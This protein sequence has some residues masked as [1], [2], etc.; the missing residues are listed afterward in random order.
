V[1]GGLANKNPKPLIEALRLLPEEYTLRLFGDFRGGEIPCEDLLAT[2][3]LELTGPIADADLPRFCRGVHCVVHTET[4]GGWANLAAEA[5]ASGT[6]L[7]ATK[8]GTLA[9]ARQ[10]ETALLIEP[11]AEEISGA[12][13][14]IFS[15]EDL[16]ASMTVRGRE[17]IEEYDWSD[18]ARRLLEICLG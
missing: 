2:G 14:R 1:I 16:A 7:I 4:T 15:S 3:K 6:P 18:Y 5:L 9:F 13:L 17:V 11:T 12:V 10:E 8:Y